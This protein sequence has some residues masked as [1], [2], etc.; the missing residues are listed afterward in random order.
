MYSAWLRRTAAA[1]NISTIYRGIA[2]CCSASLFSSCKCARICRITA[3]THKHTH[4][5][6]DSTGYR[7]A[8]PRMTRQKVNKRAR[9]CNAASFVVLFSRDLRGSG[10]RTLCREFRPEIDV[11]SK[12]RIPFHSR[13]EREKENSVDTTSRRG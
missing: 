4:E 12:E 5:L 10:P 7:S 3:Y 13:R 8:D 9:A 6:C 1:S 2:N 11:L